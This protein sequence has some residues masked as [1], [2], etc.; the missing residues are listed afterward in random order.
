MA[1]ENQPEPTI[2]VTRRQ[3]LPETPETMRAELERERLSSARLRSDFASA[4]RSSA[5]T[6]KEKAGTSA[7][8]A[9]R[10]ARHAAH[11]VQDHYLGEW[12][13]GLVRFVRRHPA[14][15]LIVAVVAGYAAGRAL[16]RR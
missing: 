16:R 4:I 2:D 15:A 12:S 6:V 7:A 3:Q 14:P 13:V 10:E 5:G 8:W 9:A 11:Y 1:T